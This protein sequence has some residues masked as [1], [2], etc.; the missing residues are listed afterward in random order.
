M[1]VDGLIRRVTRGRYV[2]VKRSPRGGWRLAA[3]G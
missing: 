1:V 3:G 2:L